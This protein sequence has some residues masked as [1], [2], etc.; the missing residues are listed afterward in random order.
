MKTILT[1]AA[2]FFAV[3][4]FGQDEVPTFNLFQ[5]T[6]YMRDTLI[7]GERYRLEWDRLE[8]NVNRV[9]MAMGCTLMKVDSPPN[10][11]AYVCIPIANAARVVIASKRV[12]G[13]TEIKDSFYVFQVKQ[14]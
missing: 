6:A 3:Y 13:K 7:S 14:P 2:V 9:V 4:T 11:D 8:P 1:T 5:D 12:R 10:Q